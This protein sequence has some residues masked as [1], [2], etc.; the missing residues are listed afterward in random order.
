VGAGASAAAMPEGEATFT[1]VDST[2][3]LLKGAKEVI[4]S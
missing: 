4:R 3:E 2:V 1:D